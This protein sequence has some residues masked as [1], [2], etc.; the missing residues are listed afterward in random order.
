MDRSTRNQLVT[1]LKKALNQV[2]RDTKGSRIPTKQV[3]EALYGLGKDLGY[4]PYGSQLSTTD[5][6]T[7]EWLYDFTWRETEDKFRIHS[8]PLVAESEAG[9]RDEVLLD[10]LKLIQARAE[11]R[12]MIYSVHSEDVIT[13]MKEIIDCFDGSKEDDFYL[14]A[15]WRSSGIKWTSYEYKV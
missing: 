4:R 10:F 11:I 14:F 5:R 8:L 9:N 15:E 12:L 7:S 6:T 3:K 13:D 1:K 2:N